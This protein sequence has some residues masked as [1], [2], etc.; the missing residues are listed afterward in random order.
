LA[1]AKT[2]EF[3]PFLLLDDFRNENPADYKAGFPWHPHS[4]DRNDYL[5]ASP[6]RLSTATSRQQ[7]QNDRRRRA[8]DDCRQRHPLTQEGPKGD[9][10]PNA[11]F[12]AVG[13]PCRQR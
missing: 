6:G 3:D 11:W 5:R 9:R 7:G 10:R 4:G 13:Q 2:K 8:M 12:P 1:S